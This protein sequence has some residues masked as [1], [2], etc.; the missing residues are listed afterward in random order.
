MIGYLTKGAWDATLEQG[1]TGT[2]ILLE[3]P[4][5]LRV[6]KQCDHGLDI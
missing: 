2:C 1:Y 3:G 6:F 5:V 4:D